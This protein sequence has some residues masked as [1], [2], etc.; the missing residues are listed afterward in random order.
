ME[1]D[2]QLSKRHD[3]ITNKIGKLTEQR[4]KAPVGRKK[5]DKSRMIG[6]LNF[7][8]YGI[9]CEMN[10]REKKNESSD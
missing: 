8:L 5:D 3:V 9:E 4:E 6:M 1:T 7:T 2:Q 10:K